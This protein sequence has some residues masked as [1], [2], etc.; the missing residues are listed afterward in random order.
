MPQFFP[1][2]F[3]PGVVRL[4]ERVPSSLPSV[5]GAGLL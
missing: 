4:W 1:L 5:G 3:R 2:G